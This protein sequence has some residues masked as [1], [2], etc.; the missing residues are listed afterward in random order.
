M[1]TQVPG[2]DAVQAAAGTDYSIAVTSAGKA[3]SWGFSDGYRTGQGTDDDI[4]EARVM[5]GKAIADKKIIW[6][7]AGGQFSILAGEAAPVMNGVAH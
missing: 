6:A 7:G 4:E 5:N 3:Y 1:P 2:I